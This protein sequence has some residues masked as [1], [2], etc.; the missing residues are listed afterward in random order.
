MGGIGIP[1]SGV[2]IAI[3]VCILIGVGSDQ[4]NS[5]ALEEPFLW[6]TNDQRLLWTTE[7]DDFSSIDF[8]GCLLG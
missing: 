8:W 3:A 1:I 7:V 4:F 2:Y 6:L 5:A